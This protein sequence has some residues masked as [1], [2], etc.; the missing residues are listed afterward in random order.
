MSPRSR[1][2]SSIIYTEFR[3]YLRI[4]VDLVSVVLPGRKVG[5]DNYL[6]VLGRNTGFGAKFGVCALFR[7]FLILDIRN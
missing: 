6:C 4:Y 1:T 3:K 2:V 5:S 7:I